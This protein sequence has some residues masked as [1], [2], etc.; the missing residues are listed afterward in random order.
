MRLLTL[1]A[2][3]AA[4]ARAVRVSSR[5]VLRLPDRSRAA[6]GA[7]LV[8]YGLPRAAWFDAAV[9]RGANF[10]LRPVAV[11]KKLVCFSCGLERAAWVLGARGIQA[12]CV[13]GLTTASVL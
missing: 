3:A 5:M 4:A 6:G 11:S 2:L 7:S 10:T 8:F 13:T 12:H 1:T 9:A